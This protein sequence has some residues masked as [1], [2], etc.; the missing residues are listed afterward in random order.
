MKRPM[1]AGCGEE[2]EMAAQE[3]VAEKQMGK[4]EKE[5]EYFVNG[6]SQMTSE[7]KLA[8]KTI[9][10]NAGFTPSGEYELSRDKE[11]HVFPDQDELVPIHKDER[12]TATFTGPTPTS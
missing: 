11:G 1:G 10:S 2:A 6:E 12:F 7:H 4:P 3:Q 5:I 8:V 9:L